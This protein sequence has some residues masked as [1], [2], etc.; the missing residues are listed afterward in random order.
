MD[1]KRF[2]SVRLEGDKCRGCTNCLKR[3]PT[4][5]IRVRG[6]RAHIIDERC[7]NCRGLTGVVAD[8]GNRGLADLDDVP[9]MQSLRVAA[10]WV[11]VQDRAVRAGEV[12]DAQPCVAGG[13][14]EAVVAREFFVVQVYVVRRRAA[15]PQAPGPDRVPTTRQL[16]V[17]Y[18]EL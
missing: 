14:E 4:E 9:G 8:D 12:G 11:A 7:I 17:G 5:A 3:C 13:L 15:Q 16:A 10:D 1:Q 18:L 2:H 6:G